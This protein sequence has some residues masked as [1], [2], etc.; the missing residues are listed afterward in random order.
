[1]ARNRTIWV[2]L[3]DDQTLVR[4]GTRALLDTLADVEVVGEAAD[5]EQAVALVDSLRPDVVLMDLIMPKLDGV[6]ATRRIT[7]AQPDARVLVVTSLGADD[8]VLA[9]V[10]AGALGYLMK[11]A[12]TAALTQAVHQVARGGAWLPPDLTRRVLKAFSH[13]EPAAALPDPLTDRELQVLTLLAQGW[14]NAQMADK[15]CVS[16]VT[17]RTHVSHIHDK[18]GCENRVQAA[19]YALRIGLVTLDGK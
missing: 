3:V 17:I 11:D 9:A 10:Q 7:T 6:E 1:M 14:T 18:L 15:M 19:L 5:G 12:D 8:K 2:L 4:K 13:P 16:E